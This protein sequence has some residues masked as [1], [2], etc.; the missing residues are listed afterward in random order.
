MF[1]SRRRAIRAWGLDGRTREPVPKRE[2]PHIYQ[3]K[4]D[5]FMADALHVSFFAC[6]VYV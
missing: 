6:S 1:G 3:G 2:F 5:S 4:P